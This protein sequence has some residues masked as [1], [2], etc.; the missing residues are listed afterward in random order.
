MWD[1]LLYSSECEIEH[2]LAIVTGCDHQKDLWSS[3]LSVAPILHLDLPPHP[4]RSIML[5]VPLCILWPSLHNLML[6]INP[7]ALSITLPTCSA[8]M[9]HWLSEEACHSFGNLPPATVR[10]VRKRIVRT[11][12]EYLCPFSSKVWQG[13]HLQ[14]CRGATGHIWQLSCHFRW[15]SYKQEICRLRS[16]SLDLEALPTL[17]RYHPRSTM[18]AA[19]YVFGK[20]TVGKHP[21]RTKSQVYT[22]AQL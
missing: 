4:W 17:L 22:L 12:I 7:T 14:S 10:W 13:I 15:N 19:H 21:L 5:S 6:C 2:W 11:S 8:S 1:C 16:T 9:S 20:S 3:T 18:L